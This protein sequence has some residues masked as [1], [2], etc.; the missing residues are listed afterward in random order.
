M[1]V[2]RTALM[3]VLLSSIVFSVVGSA[4]AGGAFGD[5]DIDPSSGRAGREI[6]ITASD[7]PPTCQDVTAAGFFPYVTG[8]FPITVTVTLW[9]QS[10]TVMLDQETDVISFG[11]SWSVVVTMPAGRAA[12]DYPISARC[13]SE[14]GDVGE[15][16]D[17]IFVLKAGARKATPVEAE[18]TLTG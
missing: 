12:G 11:G 17:Q 15:Y 4:G 18:V 7:D 16:D 9:N 2:A 3:L 10:K 8:T 1:R 6:D 13:D 5:F 14:G